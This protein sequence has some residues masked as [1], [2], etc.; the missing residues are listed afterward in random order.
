MDNPE[1]ILG[2]VKKMLGIPS[3]YKNFDLDIVMHINS[4]LFILCQLGVGP[5]SGYV[6]SDD[7]D[8]WTD[9]IPEGTNLEL[10]KSYVFMKVRVLFD[11]PQ[12]SVVMESMNRMISEFEW[13]INVASC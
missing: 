4:V 11:P 8:E 3:E 13:R 6:I 10:I 9:F 7:S 2:S 1:S 12:S 5:E